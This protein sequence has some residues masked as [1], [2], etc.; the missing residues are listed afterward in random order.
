LTDATALDRTKA[1]A[2]FSKRFELQFENQ[3]LR[4]ELAKLKLKLVASQQMK[5]LQN[6]DSIIEQE[7]KEA[8][9]KATSDKAKK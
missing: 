9:E 6:R 8:V 1:K 3:N 2:L 4:G 5:R 7:I